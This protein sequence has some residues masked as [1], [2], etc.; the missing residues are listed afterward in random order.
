MGLFH[1]THVTETGGE[2]EGRRQSVRDL[3]ERAFHFWINSSPRPEQPK[4]PRKGS[5]AAERA[6]RAAARQAAGQ[7]VVMRT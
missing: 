5:F 2:S 1:T 3:Q 4:Q 7:G 6:A